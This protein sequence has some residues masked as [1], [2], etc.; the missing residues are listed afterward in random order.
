MDEQQ[1][2]SLYVCH[3]K[4]FGFNQKLNSYKYAWVLCKT[5]SKCFGRNKAWGRKTVRSKYISLHNS[6]WC[7]EYDYIGRV[8]KKSC[9]RILK[10]YILRTG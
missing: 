2:T 8:E 3:T 10:A 9:L 5:V 4:E 6:W 7:S 1:E